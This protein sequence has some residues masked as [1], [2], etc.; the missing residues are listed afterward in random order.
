MKMIIDSRF[1][2]KKVEDLFTY[3]HLGKEKIKTIEIYVNDNKVDKS[4]L[5]K[6][7]DILELKYEDKINFIPLKEK[8]E[9]IYEDDYLL[10]VN[11][12][13]N[14]LV[15]PDSLDKSGT[16]VNIIANYYKKTNQNISVRYLH[17]IDMD[18]SGIV[19]IS[20]D[21]LTSAILNYEISEH[22][23]KREYLCLAS[24]IF[25][26]NSGKYEYRIAED[27]HIANKKRVS[28]T[29]KVAVTNYKVIKRLRKKINLCLVRLETGR[30]HQIRLHF[31]YA[32]HPLLGDKLY[33]GSLNYIKRQAL[34][35]YQVEF[36]HPILNK[37]M[38]FKAPL[39][40]DM[41]QIIE[42]F[43]NKL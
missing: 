32:G 14:M 36:I 28:K 4:F 23:V 9:I 11:K 43:E 31:S 34:H 35:S 37:K 6:E 27:R 17:R 39:P 18:T 13:I 3:F 8:L 21:I 25:K 1:N 33:N 16:L 29:G 10:L 40:R 41:Q 19:M 12:P 22:I 2:M 5:L 26:E 20:K 24:G 30:T 38:V 15:H 42:T 7:D